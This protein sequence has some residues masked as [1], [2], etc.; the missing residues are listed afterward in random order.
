LAT[1]AFH[2]TK[3]KDHKKSSGNSNISQKTIKK[4]IR[5]LSKTTKKLKKN[6]RQ[7]FKNLQKTCL[8][9]LNFAR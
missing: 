4:T 8:I 2:H 9:P 5:K 6:P 7:P 3:N 1:L